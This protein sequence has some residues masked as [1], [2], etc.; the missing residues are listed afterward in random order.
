VSSIVCL[1]STAKPSNSE[2]IYT[3]LR[4]A[5]LDRINDKEAPVRVQAVIALSKL[6]GSEEPTEVEDGEQSVAD[7]LVDI[8]AHDQSA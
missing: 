8:L 2:E 3:D 4:A 7:V 6:S 5:L 1:C